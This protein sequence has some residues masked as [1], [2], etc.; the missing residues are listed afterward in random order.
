MTIEEL[1]DFVHMDLTMSCSLPTILPTVEIRRLIEKVAL[2]WYYEH[3]PFSVIKAY[4]YLPL[5]TLQ[6]EQFTQYKYLT[7]PDEIQN[8]IWT[9]Q[10]TNRSLFSLGFGTG[11]GQGNISVN[12][13]MTNQPY[14]NSYV[15]TIGELGVYKVIIDSFS[16]MLNQ[17]A[18]T[19]LKYDYH[20][21]SK[22][23]HLL[24][25]ACSDLIL[26]TYSKIPAE[27]IFEM[28]HFKRYVLALAK[29]QLGRMLTR[30][31]MPLPGN[32]T[33]NGE[34]IKTE[35]DT[36]MDKIKEEIKAMNANTFFFMISK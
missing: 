8:V 34:A 5:D 31:N 12:N 36:E 24:T 19:T 6:T 23:F 22:R 15:T 28:D 3:H 17:L 26:E 35:G 30:Y 21:Q 20:F 4:Y 32:V 9:Y 2:S 10:V 1:V 11:N 27:D 25:S 18:K 14:L 13:G 29:Q 7:L 16:D 33:M